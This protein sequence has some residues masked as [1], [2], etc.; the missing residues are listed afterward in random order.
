MNDMIQLKAAAT[1]L[2]EEVVSNLLRLHRE[3][4]QR[5]SDYHTLCTHIKK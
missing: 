5:L 2:N 4:E 3:F 1:G